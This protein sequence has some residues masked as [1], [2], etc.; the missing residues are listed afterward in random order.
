[1]IELLSD[2]SAWVSLAVLTL[3]EVVLGIDNI[4]F[5]T[6]LCARLPK[7]QQLPARRLGL[8][9]ALASRLMLLLGI[10]WVMRLTEPLF[11][12]VVEWTGKDLIL[13][14]GGLFLLYKS[15]SE[16]YESVEHPGQNA[17]PASKD[18]DGPGPKKVSYSGV[19]LQIMVLDVVFSLDSV[20]TAVGMAEHIPVMVTAMLIAVGV[21]MVFAGSIGDFIEDHPSVRVLALAFLVL[22]GVMLI[23]EGTGQHVSK[24]YIYAAMGFSL[25]VQMLNIRMEKRHNDSASGAAK[26]E[27]EAVG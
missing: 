14:G 19:I 11:T 3:M 26:L 22:I 12:L 5:I 10:A 23:A 8:G 16:I 20:I 1:M 9:V 15:T 24:G 18:P 7:A 2:P 13:V 25:L 17:A 6:I 27:D 21:M 4:V